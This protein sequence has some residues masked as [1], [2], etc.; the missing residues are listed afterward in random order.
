MADPLSTM[1]QIWAA[2]K[3]IFTDLDPG[4]AQATHLSAPRRS[5]YKFQKL[6]PSTIAATKKEILWIYNCGPIAQSYMGRRYIL[7]PKE[8]EDV[9]A[10]VIVHETEIQW[11]NVGE[12]KMQ[13]VEMD[14]KLYAMDIICPSG[15]VGCDL[16]PW[17]VFMTAHQRGT[18]EFDFDLAEAKANLFR[19]YDEL[20]QY[21][22]KLWD[23]G[24]YLKR[25]EITEI[26]RIACRA[27][28]NERPWCLVTQVK[29]T[30]PACR[31]AIPQNCVQ[32]PIP[33]CGA[34]LNWQKAYQFGKIS[35][36][37]YESALAEGLVVVDGTALK[38]IASAE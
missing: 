38:G 37:R 20:I 6:S 32:C 35:K 5:P 1:K 16:R 31:G 23:T 19:K 33:H 27:L 25:K 9:G 4:A 14:G 12:Y 7:P 2:G 17:G 15:D 24:D 10:P 34:I 13:A 3:T 26:Y 30:C 28:G 18:P 21:A 11:T 36:D 29:V 22:D 8:G